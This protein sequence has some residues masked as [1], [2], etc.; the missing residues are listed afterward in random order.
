MLFCMTHG[1][2]LTP[3]VNKITTTTTTL[4]LSKKTPVFLLDVI[5]SAAADVPVKFQSD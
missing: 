1:S 5:L 4:Q 3:S 2:V